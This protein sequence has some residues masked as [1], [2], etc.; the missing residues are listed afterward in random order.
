MPEEYAL[1]G[2]SRKPTV[3]IV[4]DEPAIRAVVAALLEEEGYAVRRA[5]N[6][7]EAL[8]VVDS[9][10]V[11]LILSDV[12][13]PHL[14]GAS[15]VRRLRQRGVLVPVVLMSAVYADVDLPGVPFVPK[16]FDV[17]RLLEAIATA[18]IANGHV[19]Q[20]GSQR[21]IRAK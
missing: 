10:P 3:L 17:D 16:P 18:M 14:D 1:D 11:D 9:A 5:R 12:V 20:I 21:A 13:M 15:L 7:L 6:G 2:N 19:D 8:A 4:E